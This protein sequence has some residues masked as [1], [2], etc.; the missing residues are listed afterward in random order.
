MAIDFLDKQD[1][2]TLI[3][4][5][6][7]RCISIYLPMARKG[8]DVQ[9]NALKL[10]NALKEVA[11]TLGEEGLKQPEID[12]LLEMP[13]DLVDDALYW[14]HQ[15]EGLA[16]FIAS[17]FFEAYRLPL[18]FEPLTVVSHR[19][20]IKP[21]LPLMHDD[22]PFYVLA[23]SQN[24]VRLFKGTRNWIEEVTAER[25]PG[26]LAE[27]LAYDDPEEQ[28]QVHTTTSGSAGG[29]AVVHH[30]HSPVD[31][32]QARLRRFIKRVADGVKDVVR[33]DPAP[34]VVAAVDYLHP[35]FQDAFGNA[36]LLEKGIEGNPENLSA[37]TLREQAWKI[38]APHILQP[39]KDAQ[40][41]FE[42]LAHGNQ[43]G[44]D[45]HHVVTRALRGRVDTLFVAV[46]DHAWGT[47]DPQEDDM[48]VCGERD[49]GNEDLMDFAAVQTLANGGTVYALD[50]DDV[51]GQTGMAAIFRF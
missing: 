21:L 8:V 15:Q 33:S 11:E 43:A 2:E 29:P 25:L 23:L 42:S 4:H 3:S 22:G 31:E 39:R 26:D 1:F 17:D 16:L 50:V 12:A 49:Q 10:K 48:T 45:L 18:H 51:P 13:R 27:A 14:Q 9:G 37:E 35:I 6:D 5:D 28:V 20:H 44:D 30:G 41:R 46:N 7:P 40:E 34:L 24:N 38:V 19:F 47:Y 32:K 36:Q